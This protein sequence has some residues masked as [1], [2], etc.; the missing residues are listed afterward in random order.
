MEKNGQS[1]SAET[2]KD[3]SGGHLSLQVNP[4]LIPIFFQL[5]GQ[6]FSINIQTGATVKDLLCKQ[7]GIQ[8]D[9]LAQRIQT[10]FLNAKVV[11]DIASAIVAEESTLALSGAM[12]GLVGAI[13]RSGG[14]Y[15]AMRKR[16][17][18]EES[19]SSSQVLSAKITLKLMNIVAKELG[20]IFL[21]QGIWLKGQTLREFIERRMDDLKAGC[22]ACELDRKP[23]EFTSLQGIDWRD[24]MVLLQVYSEALDRATQ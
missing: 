17:S 15:A 10:I 7:L 9:Y 21:Q 13:L 23:I 8:E 18:H 20:P 3:V 19:K 22:R 1:N 24:D 4:K 16:I 11:D 6:G 14:Y 12:P 5:L 2:A